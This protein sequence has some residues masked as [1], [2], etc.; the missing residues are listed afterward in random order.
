MYR[1]KLKSPEPDQPETINSKT[2]IIIAVS[3]C[4]LLIILMTVYFIK[5]S[6]EV[7]SEKVNKSNLLPDKFK[8]DIDSILHVFGIDSSWTKEIRNRINEPGID[9]NKLWIAKEIMIPEDL[10]TIEINFELSEYFRKNLLSGKVTEDPKSRNLNILISKSDTSHSIIGIMK[11]I[12]SDSVKRNASE[13]CIILDSLDFL[14]SDEAVNIL[15]TSENI[16]AIMPLRNDKADYQ[17]LIMESGKNYLIELTIG[18]ENNITADF[19]SDMKSLTW[20]SKVKSISLNFPNSSAIIIRDQLGDAEFENNV[21]KEFES[22]KFKVYPDSIYKFSV[23]GDN[24]VKAIFSDISKNSKSGLKKLLFKVKLNSAEFAEYK[25]EV[26]K[27]KKAGYKFL[28]FREFAG[29]AD[30][31][32]VNSVIK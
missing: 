9:K 19:K 29:K 10:M 4:L 11:F 26:Y 7:N 30:T 3:L 17:S 13:V 20:K 12:Y 22:Y 14:S 5:G 28:S 27:F 18:D 24:R 1:R 15:S 8:S 16:S 25:T 31:S 32:A 2:K 6:D 21:R 23:S